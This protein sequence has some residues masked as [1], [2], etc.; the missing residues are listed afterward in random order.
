MTSPA[1]R[2][3]ATSM[4]PLRLLLAGGTAALLLLPTAALAQTP[5]A[6][7]QDM[8]CTGINAAGTDM[9]KRATVHLQL[10]DQDNHTTLARQEVTTSAAGTFRT[11]VRAQLNRVAS[12]RLTVAGPDGRQLAFA[13]H[14]MDKDMPMCSLPFTGAA[15]S[16]PLLDGAIGL[17]ALGALTL[18]LAAW[19]LRKPTPG[20]GPG[21]T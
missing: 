19:R 11:T 18:A 10:L 13:D 12:I 17:M 8:T 15:G 4:R 5:R 7:L 21:L 20:R 14:A 6:A 2:K 16:A 9:P 1:A 3:D